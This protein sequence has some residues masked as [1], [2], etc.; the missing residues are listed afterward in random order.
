MAEGGL[1]M[2]TNSSGPSQFTL[3][4][5]RRLAGTII[6]VFVLIAIGV[7]SSEAGDVS[8]EPNQGPVGTSVTANGAGWP[9]RTLVYAFFDLNQQHVT[10]PPAAVADNGTF[11]T[12][13]CVPNL[14]SG[15]HPTF[16][17]I[18]G[19]PGVY[20]G[21]I[22]TITAGS[23]P[24]QTTCADAYFIGAHGVGEGPDGSSRAISPELYETA[25][26]FDNAKPRQNIVIKAYYLEYPAA[27]P[28]DITQIATTKL[29]DSISM[30]LS[31]LTSAKNEGLVALGKQVTDV[32]RECKNPTIVLAGYSLGA[33]VIDEWLSGNKSLWQYIKAVEVYG[34]P[35]WYRKGQDGTYQ[36]VALR[37]RSQDVETVNQN[38]YK[39]NPPGYP[40]PLAN[41][42]QSLCLSKDPVCGEG[43]NSDLISGAVQ[44]TDFLKCPVFFCEHLKYAIAPGDNRT[45]YGSTKGGGAFLASQAFQ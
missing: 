30:Y 37:F 42:W 41:R 9:P 20:S 35:L 16:F 22:F 2:S 1:E 17:T 25:L 23:V 31:K 14:S 36:G 8:L 13:F 32:L 45:G 24:C 4:L 34:D 10:T 26:N 27:D 18:K 21:P 15:V 7:A 19:L 40:L 6:G 39:N 44:M 5:A 38:P 12:T 28:P 11:K 3:I 33:W 43:Y 29:E